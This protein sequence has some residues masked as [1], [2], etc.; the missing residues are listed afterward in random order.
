MENTKKNRGDQNTGKSLRKL[1]RAGKSVKWTTAAFSVSD[2]ILQRMCTLKITRRLEHLSNLSAAWGGPSVSGRVSSPGWGSET[3]Q[4]GLEPPSGGETGPQVPVQGHSQ[5]AGYLCLFILAS[6]HILWT[7]VTS[8]FLPACMPSNTFI[9]V[10]SEKNTSCAKSST[11]KV[12]F[13]D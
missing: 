10:S 8:L 2:K 7:L 5:L 13:S 1:K 3:L 6:C 11:L 4:Q 12:M 9:F